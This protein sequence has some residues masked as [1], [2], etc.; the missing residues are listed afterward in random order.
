MKKRTCTAI[1]L[2]AGSGKR[3]GTKTQKQYLALEGKP[4]LY[5]SL[6]TFEKAERIDDIILVVGESE[7]SYCQE[8][9]VRRYGFTKVQKVVAGGNER[10]ESVWNALQVCDSADYVFIHDGARPFVSE[11][12]IERAYQTVISDRACV[13]GMPVKD[14]IKIADEEGYIAETPNRDYVW[15]IQTPQVFEKELV[16]TAYAKLMEN[17]RMKVT[18][19]AQVVESMMYEDVRLVYGS[20]ENI[21]ITTPE[22]LEIA[23][24]FLKNA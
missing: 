23:K 1:I 11:D 22:D 10:Y 6:R 24:L 18:D 9:I 20:Y 16:Y 3:M 5:Y 13:I 17:P 15:M 4:V 21:K 12:M 7:I 19:D 14:T 2:A 8:E